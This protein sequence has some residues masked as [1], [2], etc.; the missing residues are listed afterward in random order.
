MDDVDTAPGKAAGNAR[1]AAGDGR[2]PIRRRPIGL[3]PLRG[4]EAAARLLSFTLAAAELHLTQSAISRQVAALEADLGVR[5]F[6][7]RIRSLVLTSAGE[8][9]LRAVQPSL[10]GIDRTVNEIRGTGTAPRLVLTTYPSFAS[11]WLVPRLAAFQRAHPGIEVRIDADNRALDLEAEDVD[12]ALRRSTPRDAPSD[13]VCLAEEE[14]TPALSPELLNRY[15]GS[16]EVPADLLRL[17]LIEIDDDLPGDAAGTWS[18]WFASAGIGEERDASTPIMVVT[19]VD[20]SMQAAARGQG[21]VMARRPFLDDMLATGQLVVPFPQQRV[22]TGY[23][24]YLVV[25]RHSRKRKEVA[26]LRT[27]L[28]A[29]FAAGQV[30]IG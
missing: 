12:L 8:R 15:G 22:K 29:E 19:F 30:P 2:R 3:A 10:A 28:L 6:A 9:L 1:P 4:F 27:W 21:V 24:T 11:L 14:V 20:Q 26:Q 18:N 13:A 5:L 7:R 23:N 17:P 25:N 16:L